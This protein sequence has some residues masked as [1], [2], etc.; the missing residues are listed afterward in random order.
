M[1]R[2]GLLVAAGLLLAGVGGALLW[3]GAAGGPA[4]LTVAGILVVIVGL[5]CLRVGYWRVRV[6]AMTRAGLAMRSPGGG[7][8]PGRDE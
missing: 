1:R 2:T 4:G 3:R 5:V 8:G 7:D 6:Q